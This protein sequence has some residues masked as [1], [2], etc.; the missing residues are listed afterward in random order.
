MPRIKDKAKALRKERIWL[1]VREH[2]GIRQK[3]LSELSGFGNRTVNNYLNELEFEGKV[4]KEGVFWF[5]QEFQETKLRQFE[6]SAEEATTLYLAARLFVKQSDKRNEFA[7]S[8]LYRLAEVLKS[9]I[10]VDRNI[11]EAAQKLAEREEQPGYHDTF[12]TLVRAYLNRH[13][14]R[15][16]YK[17]LWR[18]SF[19]TTF[20]IYLI[21]PSAIGFSTY[22]I[23]YSSL[24]G[25]LRSYKLS[26]I[27]SV[28][29]LR[30]ET[31]A[32]PE[33][34]PG[35]SIFDTA[36]SIITGEETIRVV[37][38]FSDKVA[39]RVL[40]TNWHPSQGYA[41][42]TEKEGYLRWWVDVAD[43]TDISPWI[44]GWGANVEV[45]E[46]EDLR[47]KMKRQV[48][49]LSEAYHLRPPIEHLPYQLLYAKTNR[50]N[51][52]EIHLLLYHL[53]DVGQVA[54]SLWNDVLTSGFK[55]D[56]AQ[57]LGL[58]EA[59]MGRFLAFLVG[60][61][62]LGKASPAYQDKYA[63]STLKQKLKEA[64]LPV[65]KLSYNEKTNSTPH[66]T[67]TTW[68]LPQLLEE[69][70]YLEPK[71]AKKIGFALG[72]HHG[73]WPSPG[74]TQGIR[75]DAFPMWDTVRRDLFWE[76][77]SVFQP[78]PLSVTPTSEAMNIFLTLLS[79][80][81]SVADWVGSNDDYFLLFDKPMSTREYA[82]LSA[83]RAKKAL[84]D[85][86][87]LGWQPDGQTQTFAEMFAYL[88][89][90]K[91]IEP[92]QVQKEVMAQ[93]AAL[94]PP[95]LMILES[96]TGSGKTEVSLYQADT[97]LQSYGGRGLYVAMPTQATSNQMFDRALKFLEHRYPQQQINTLLLHGQAAFDEKLEE[98][99]LNTIGDK[100]DAGIVA[101][102]WFMQKSKRTLLAPFG[103]GTV[104]QTLLS[105][106]QTNHF[107][108]RLFG[109]SHKIVIFDEVHAYDTYMNT[110][111]EHLLT[112]LRAIGTSVIILSA[113]LPAD[114]R[115]RLVSAY[116]G[117]DLPPPDN[118]DAPPYPAL[119]LAG[120]NQ[121]PHTVGLTPPAD[122]SLGL[123]W[124]N[125]TDPTRNRDPQNIVT[126]LKQALADGGCA[127]VICNTV[128]RAQTIYQALKAAN[129]DMPAD[130]LILFHARYPAAWRKERED[131]VIKLFGKPEADGTDH[132]PKNGQKAIVVATQ[133]IEQSLDLDFDVMITDLAPIDLLI[134]RAGRLQRHPFRDADRPGQVTRRLVIVQ[135]DL[136]NGLPD[137][138]NDVFV[139]EPY[140]LLETYRLLQNKYPTEIKLP[141]QTVAL[142]EGVYGQKPDADDTEARQAYREMMKNN[143]TAHIKAQ[144]QLVGDVTDT[145]LL[146]Q[147]N[148]ELDEDNPNVHQSFRAKTRDIAPG[149]SLICLHETEKGL[150]L[151]PDNPD[152]L[153]NLEA[154]PNSEQV[155]EFLRRML[156]VQ[157][158]VLVNHFAPQAV[159]AGW[160]KNAVLRHTRHVVFQNGEYRFTY[161]QNDKDESYILSLDPELGLQLQKEEA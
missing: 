135:P 49:G 17:P 39:Q 144:E 14:V 114:T 161:S 4:Y 74:T 121:A 38:R 22:L 138:G 67:V 95:A 10:P 65:D 160:R 110:L 30:N 113:T 9:D 136:P 148:L 66:A 125:S 109:L 92:H 131:K 151:D 88:N 2:N 44:R 73:A 103:V 77:R 146:Y 31:Y 87:W 99:K 124:L 153:C 23:G 55:Q 158:W 68:A 97:W 19:E 57:S 147:T 12:Q 71:F 104:D 8:A 141:G 127:A 143:H 15:L 16:T 56:I 58:A 118:P 157:N 123:H 159:P 140:I 72:G 46:P 84:K 115:Q 54:L 81:T 61:H 130:N 89:S 111:F 119:T 21:E 120:A 20:E 105:I 69:Y 134:Q 145:Q 43:T 122:I 35:L 6:L 7:E 132:R 51:N 50:S 76:M 45:L 82:T 48:Q 94:Q 36:W 33:E 156:T 139:Y 28:E 142:I 106:L 63:A 27:E 40:E 154:V 155:R 137:F 24:V 96:L 128:K 86:G 13:K 37:L 59:E 18:D 93:T 90:T 117:Q 152:T 78:P 126:F 60:L 108:V 85:L 101:M 98:I 79:G 52:E 133:V 53:I 150:L 26:R 47:Q 70:C 102:S 149:V 3:E 80:L 83:Q 91:T 64:A 29:V 62:D 129:L 5:E 100:E 32:I 11:R 34:F 42:D 112:W 25:K 1:L 41:W 75:D 107:F 116:T